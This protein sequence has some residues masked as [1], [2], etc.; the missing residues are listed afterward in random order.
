MPA[1]FKSPSSVDQRFLSFL[2]P[3]CKELHTAFNDAADKNFW[4]G[5]ASLG[6][7]SSSR[8]FATTDKRRHHALHVVEPCGRLLAC[9]G[10]LDGIA[11]EI[12]SFGF[13]ELPC[14]AQRIVGPFAAIGAFIETNRYCFD[15]SLMCL[16][17][18]VVQSHEDL[19]GK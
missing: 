10:A 2:G 11:D 12:Y 7:A 6:T 17:G 16:G 14:V 19:E 13:G 15:L 4:P 3:P 5:P 18:L 1:L 9:H 8:D